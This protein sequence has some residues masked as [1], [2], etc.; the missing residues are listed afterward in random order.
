MALMDSEADHAREYE[1]L[2]AELADFVLDALATRMAA[3]EDPRLG[4]ALT[5]AIDR[6]VD[7][8]VAERLGAVEWPDPEAFADQVIAAAGSR[9]GNVGD[10][11][12]T[13]RRRT[14]EEPSRSTR[15]G[16]RSRGWSR[17]QIG[18]LAVI[19]LAIL[20]V[21]LYFFL[22]GAPAPVRT[23]TRGDVT[24]IEPTPDGA[25]N[26]QLPPANGAAPAPAAP[27]QN[28]QGPTP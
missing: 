19:V 28:L 6:R 23:E 8:A 17:T 14:A 16:N 13:T 18:I 3:G 27:G 24:F 7:Q 22:R 11:A 25:T 9:G 5:D 2:R 12:G 4:K 10:G 20:A 21:G 26:A 15:S 1:R